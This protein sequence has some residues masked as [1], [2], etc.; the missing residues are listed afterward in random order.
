MFAMS[1]AYRQRQAMQSGT[2]NSLPDLP[3]HDGVVR[4]LDALV[5]MGYRTRPRPDGWVDA[6]STGIATLTIRGDINEVK[7]L[8][9]R[10]IDRSDIRFVS[11][12]SMRLDY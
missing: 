9:Q 11:L 8:T 5:E 12:T 10:L 6:E 7:E 2:G 1:M 3:P 4:M